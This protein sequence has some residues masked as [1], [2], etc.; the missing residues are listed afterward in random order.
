MHNT[1]YNS[2]SPNR[3]P[4]AQLAAISPCNLMK[5]P[6]AQIS[7]CPFNY[8]HIQTPY[9]LS[10]KLAYQWH[11]HSITVGL[12]RKTCDKTWWV[13]QFVFS[14]QSPHIAQGYIQ[15]SR[16]IS[17]E[18]EQGDPAFAEGK[19]YLLLGAQSGC[20]IVLHASDP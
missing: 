2:I 11:H 13:T 6:P 19:C 9:F 20:R 10:G 4:C 7:T 8:V 15:A 5:L 12:L 1:D 16:L 18:I 14:L 17:H 3:L